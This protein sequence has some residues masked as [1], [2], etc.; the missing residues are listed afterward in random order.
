MA[1][2]LLATNGSGAA[3]VDAPGG[4]NATAENFTTE[5]DYY[6]M[7]APHLVK[8]L[9]Y[10]NGKGKLTTFLKAL[11]HKKTYAS[12]T[13]QHQQAGRTMN[14]VKNVAVAGNVFTFPSPH[15][16]REKMIVLMSD[17]NGVTKQGTVTAIASPT[18][19]TILNNAVGAY[20]F[21]GNVTVVVDFSNS[22][23]PGTDPFSTG[24]TW[25]TT[26]RKNFT[27]IFKETQSASNSKWTQSMWLQTASGDVKWVSEEVEKTGIVFDNLYEYTHLFKYRIADGSPAAL[28]GVAQGSKCITEQIEQYGNISND[29]IQTKANLDDITYRIKQQ[30]IGITEFTIHADHKQLIYLQ[31]ICAGLNASFVNGSHWGM[32]NNDKNMGINLDFTSIYINGITFYFAPLS[33]LDEV[34]SLGDSA[35][36][37]SGVAYFIIPGGNTTV[38]KDGN[39]YS[40][41]HICLYHRE[42]DGMDRGRMVEIFG[43]MGTKQK[44]DKTDIIFTSESTNLLLGTN[45]FFVG[46]RGP[47]FY[48]YSIFN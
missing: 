16:L 47:S 48:V 14:K 45:A 25:G 3:V 38:M 18:V 42:L 35:F 10:A 21:T 44:A 20:G 24:R 31:N 23:G 7:N 1:F 22:F 29:Y 9:Y 15:N 19:A 4:I 8:E 40:E 32:F 12:D 5:Y 26:T 39:Q 37:D 41:P 30:N 34:T 17:A 36:L 28:A 2:T 6:T 11:G 46:R 43:P 27:G 33:V 13:V